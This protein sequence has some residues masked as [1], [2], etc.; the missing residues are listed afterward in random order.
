MSSALGKAHSILSDWLNGH[1]ACFPPTVLNLTDGESTD[2]DPTLPAESIRALSSVDGNVLLFNLHV[3][4]EG[5]PPITF[6]DSDSGLP[7]PYARLMFTMS[8]VLPTPMR[9]HAHTLGF[10]VS[11][12]SRGFV[13]NADIAAIIQFLDIGTRV[14]DLR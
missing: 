12:G 3:C 14:T 4:S 6:P 1:P 5:G 13:Y 7:N 2:G 10:N 8:S 11:D 9:T